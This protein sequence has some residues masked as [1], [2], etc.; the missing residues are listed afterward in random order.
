MPP[1]IDADTA[2][3]PGEFRDEILLLGWT[4]ARVY[5]RKPE[6]STWKIFRVRGLALGRKA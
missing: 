3:A 4:V 6:S 5:V 2:R 1:R